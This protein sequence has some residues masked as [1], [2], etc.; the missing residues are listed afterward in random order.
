MTRL[1]AITFADLER[2]LLAVG[3]VQ[4][5]TTGHHKVFR[6]GETD[7]IVLLPLVPADTALDD[8]HLVAVRKLVDE[9]GVIASDAFDGLLRGEG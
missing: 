4:I 2:V 8:T 3:F 7:T 5:P 1:K 6:H 9:R